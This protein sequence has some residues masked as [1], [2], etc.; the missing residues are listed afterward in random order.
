MVHC[1]TKSYIHTPA[2]KKVI[3]S[4]V[5]WTTESSFAKMLVYVLFLDIMHVVNSFVALAFD[6]GVW[7]Q[8]H[9][10]AALPLRE[11]RDPGTLL[12]GGWVSLKADIDVVVKITARARNRTLLPAY[13]LAELS[14]LCMLC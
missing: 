11:D 12:P 8:H 14:Q 13:T 7:Y 10:L 1:H 5:S 3:K 9:A 4:S 6:G 2:V